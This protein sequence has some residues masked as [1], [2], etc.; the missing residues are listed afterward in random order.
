VGDEDPSYTAGG[1]VNYYNHCENNKE[2]P[3]KNKFLG[4]YPQGM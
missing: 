3:Q 1:N 2:A 4:I